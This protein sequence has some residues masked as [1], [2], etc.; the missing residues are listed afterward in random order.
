VSHICAS[1]RVAPI[2]LPT[3]SRMLVSRLFIASD[4]ISKQTG[5]NLVKLT[6]IND[7]SA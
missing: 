7:A 6:Q 1:P 5:R 2:M 4:F 3:M